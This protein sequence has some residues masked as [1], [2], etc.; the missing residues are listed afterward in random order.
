MFHFSETDRVK[1][2]ADA[3]RALTA[4]DNEVLADRLATREREEGCG[5]SGPNVNRMDARIS[6]GRRIGPNQQALTAL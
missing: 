6:P 2:K 3:L 5:N 1:A 4:H